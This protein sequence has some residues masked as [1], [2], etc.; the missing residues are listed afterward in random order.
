MEQ[1]GRF[2]GLK[3]LLY[4]RPLFL[5]GGFYTMRHVKNR[6]I[7]GLILAGGKSSR[8]YPFNKVLSDLTGSGKSLIQQSFERLGLPRKQTYVLT[9]AD[10]VA[11]IRRQLK[12]SQKQFF[13]DPVRR[14]TWP[15]I[16]WAMAHLRH[17]N[18][19]AVMAIVT[20]DH[21]IQKIPAFRASLK[22]AIQL[23]I[24]KPTF[25]MLGI[26]PTRDAAEWRSFG[27][28]RTRGDGRVVKFEE[29]PSLAGAKRMIREGRWAW[30]SGMF[31]FRI[32]TAEAAM[33][34][35]QPGM[36]NLYR[37]MATA[38]ALG[39]GKAAALLFEDFADKIPHPLDPKRLVDNSIDYAIMTPLIGKAVPGL[40]A[41]GVQKPAFDWT[42]LGQWSALRQV[43]KADR[44]GN[45][46]IGQVALGT[47][48]RN[49]IVVAE[50]GHSVRCSNVQNV[51]IT[52]A[53][54]KALV[55]PEEKLADIKQ[56][57]QSAAKSRLVTA[58]VPRIPISWH[59]KRL[60]VS[61]KPGFIR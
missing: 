34:E 32:S 59:G 56:Y 39:Q 22:K 7:F 50:K 20:G 17:Q 31:F 5:E 2:L 24:R 53:G 54:S 48:V 45:I 30:N 13:V 26:T 40:S 18:P 8:L 51:V 37:A 61:G 42:D 38:I 10:M 29:K 57:V 9:V 47:N 12:F 1:R 27:C 16:L 35:F 6:P 23:A 21:V 14:G 15:A 33:R 28:F 11:P 46:R 19:D 44:H 43:V 4:S 41:H 25:V 49:C 36:F 52:V 55:L 58:G 60:V 3:D